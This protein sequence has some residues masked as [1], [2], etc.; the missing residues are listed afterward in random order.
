MKK[1]LGWSV[2]IVVS[3]LLMLSVMRPSLAQT[4]DPSNVTEAV[5]KKQDVVFVYQSDTT[6]YNCAA[7]QDKL[8]LILMH[9]GARR[10]VIVQPHAC[11]DEAGMVSFKMTLH[12]PVPATQE[13]VKALTTY[14]S[15][16]VLTARVRGEQLLTAEELPR[17][18]AEWR[19]VSFARNRKLRLDAGDCDLVQQLRRQVLPKLSVNVTHE[20][21]CSIM[22]RN[23]GPPRLTVSAL[24]ALPSPDAVH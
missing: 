11:V 14:D 24:V 20:V 18:A 13:N 15:Q 16:A 1:N 2:A 9:I 22:S 3:A 8:R 7:L 10:D 6:Y 19:T 23:L 4:S 21:R 5:W 17:F 12:S